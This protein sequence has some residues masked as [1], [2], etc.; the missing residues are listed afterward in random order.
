MTR[1]RI[2]S[3][4]P[5]SFL[6][7]MSPNMA[8]P[9]PAAPSPKRAAWARTVARINPWRLARLAAF[10]ALTA[11]PV[12]WAQTAAP[13]PAPTAAPASAAASAPAK[14]PAPTI[15]RWV[16]ERGVV[17]FSDAPP[18]SSARANVTEIAKVPPLT[19]AEQAK[20]RDLMSQYEQ[21]LAKVPAA[22]ASSPAASAPQ[23]RRPVAAAPSGNQSC[24]AQWDR[25]GAAYRCLDGFRAA[26]GVVRPEAFAVCPVVKEPD[27]PAPSGR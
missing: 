18:P 13:T 17:H 25:Y 24:A 1:I 14:P 16:D 12:A 20:A 23:P 21:Q 22:P 10:T 15:K 6:G 7:A 8:P 9:P 26:K 19:P 3:T 27:C 11:A 5:M 2:L 4:H